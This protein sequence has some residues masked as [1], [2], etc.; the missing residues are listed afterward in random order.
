M[1]KRNAASAVWQPQRSFTQNHLWIYRKRMGYTQKQVAH[2]LGHK[3]AS[4]LS[5]Y[6]HGK[7]LPSLETAL[8]LEIVLRVPVAFLYQDLCRKLKREIRQKE[9]ALRPTSL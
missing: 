1:K 9:E 5:G 4:H 6:E 3:T 2:L 8:K 7:R